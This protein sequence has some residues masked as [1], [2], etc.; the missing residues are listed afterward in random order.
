M[1]VPAPLNSWYVVVAV[2]PGEAA[3]LYHFHSSA[4]LAEW[5]G[6]EATIDRLDPAA[7]VPV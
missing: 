3:E 1:G 5:A 6:R 7:P 2:A 4:C